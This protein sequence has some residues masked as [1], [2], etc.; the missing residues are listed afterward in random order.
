[1]AAPPPL[2]TPGDPLPPYDEVVKRLHDL[3]GDSPSPGQVY[4]KA[5]QG[6]TQPE[7]ETL[8]SAHKDHFP[9][10]TDEEKTQFSIGMSKTSSSEEAIQYLQVAAASACSAAQDIQATFNQLLLK[11]I[12]I[13]KSEKSDFQTSL[14]QLQEVFRYSSLDKLISYPLT[15]QD[16]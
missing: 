5:I 13:D 11:L 15:S 16:I 6:L 1:M 4:E 12:E 10:T 8:T 7:L 14:K 2:Y 9:L 3:V